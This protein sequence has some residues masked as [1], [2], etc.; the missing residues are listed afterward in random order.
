[1]CYT[2]IDDV[3]VNKNRICF[4]FKFDIASGIGFAAKKQIDN[5][6]SN[7]KSN[8]INDVIAWIGFDNELS[9]ALFNSQRFGR[10][11][12]IQTSM[13]IEDKLLLNKLNGVYTYFVKENGQWTWLESI[14]DVVSKFDFDVQGHISSIMGKNFIAQ[15]EAELKKSKQLDA[16]FKESLSS[17]RKLNKEISE[18]KDAPAQNSDIENAKDVNDVVSSVC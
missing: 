1:M 7:I 16:S 11:Y 9:Q 17:M 18:I 14:E 4:Y 13:I 12:R 10:K 15:H 3:T 5:Q 2:V 8:D 6:I